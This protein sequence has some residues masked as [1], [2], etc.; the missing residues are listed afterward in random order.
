[1]EIRQSLSFRKTYKKLSKP[2]QH[3]V[4]GEIRKIMANPEIGVEKK[5]DLRGIF[6]HKF[7]IHDQQYLLAY[8]FD[9]ITLTLLMLGVHE[10]FY[11]DLKNIF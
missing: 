8:T 2:Q 7:K 9:P 5:Q 3:I 6:V 10:N 11:R 1:M 4:N